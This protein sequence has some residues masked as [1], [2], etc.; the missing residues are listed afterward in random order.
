[1]KKMILTLVLASAS[2]SAF[3][4]YHPVARATV[5]A[6]SDH[7]VA[8]AAAT[9]NNGRHPVARATTVASSDHPVAAAAVTSH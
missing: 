9:G 8:V 7:P 5:V 2:V 4:N 1:M 3:A 6:S